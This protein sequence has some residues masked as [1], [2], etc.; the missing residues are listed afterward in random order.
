MARRA[1]HRDAQ[2]AAVT[3]VQ[4]F[5]GA[6]N[7]NV[8]FHILLPDA[9]FVPQPGS[10]TLCVL[11]LPPPTGRDIEALLRRLARRV[12]ALCQRR[13]AW[14]EDTE[15]EPLP[16][17]ISEAMRKLPLTAEAD[18][19]SVDELPGDDQPPSRPCT[20][21]RCA[22]LDGYSLHA[23][24]MVRAHNRVG[25]ERLCRYGLR[26]AFAQDRLSLTQDGR[27]RLSLAKPWPHKDGVSELTMDGVAFL[28]RLAPLI[29]PP[30]AN[31]IRYHGLFAPR[32][33]RRD[34]L[35]PAPV[36]PQAMR[37]EGELRTLTAGPQLA[38]RRA[39]PPSAAPSPGSPTATPCAPPSSPRQAAGPIESAAP[40]LGPA[41]TAQPVLARQRP[42]RQVLRW[43]E[44]LRR[45]FL[46]DI[47]T[48]GRCGGAMTVLCYLTDERVVAKILTHLKLPPA[49]PP[50]ALARLPKQLAFD[51]L[52]CTDTASDDEVGPAP[53]PG[54]S[55][56]GARAGPSRSPP[57]DPLDQSAEIGDEPW[58]A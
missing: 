4:R 45:V 11:A 37:L 42:E 56:P 34:A 43:P 48:C 9:V 15:D 3:F 53:G 49:P 28:R 39:D 29:P 50:P 12:D 27:V 20:S 55:W 47:L 36:S 44:L 13:L 57:G 31:L 5:G 40:V 33:K 18:Q 54:C 52:D 25:L 24:T 17:A 1:G 35:P 23:D 30:F 58:G 14:V 2:T 46:V 10:D 22:W 41:S 16:G 8:H 19:P 7:C 26:P 32:A 51:D 21:R 38:P 6:L